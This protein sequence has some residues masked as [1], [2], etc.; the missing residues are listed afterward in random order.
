MSFCIQ[1]NGVAGKQSLLT[2]KDVTR[3][4]SVPS[5]HG[6]S[7]RQIDRIIAHGKLERSVQVGIDFFFQFKLVPM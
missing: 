1:G 7:G 3:K 2:I 6:Y 4:C 5:T